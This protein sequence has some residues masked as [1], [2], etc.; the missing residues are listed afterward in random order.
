[1]DNPA[2]PRLDAIDMRLLAQ[3]Q[4]DART[5]NMVL[6]ERAGL[7]PSPCSRRIRLL[8]Q[9]GVIRGYRA[10]L[11]RRQIGAGLTIFCNVR[12][13]RH[14]EEMADAFIAEVLAIPE[15]VACHL[16][17]GDYDFL[18]EIVAADMTTYEQTVLR[19]LIALPASRDIHSSFAMRSH[20]IDGPLPLR[21]G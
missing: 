21:V 2:N 17:S 10:I 9:A 14:S 13:D 4:A 16:V 15:V 6:A 3:L 8:E 5:P 7:S 11:D 12:I 19:R 20:R 1:M 18:L